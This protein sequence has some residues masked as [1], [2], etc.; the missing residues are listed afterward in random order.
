MSTIRVIALATI[1]L[2][3]STSHVAAHNK[4]V[5][6]PMEGEEA[7]QPEP[8]RWA[9]VSFDGTTASIVGSSGVTSVAKFTN[10]SVTVTFDVPITECGLVVSRNVLGNFSPAEIGISVT[11]PGSNSGHDARVFLL[12]ES[13]A[14]DTSHGVREAFT[15]QALC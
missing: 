14:F 11:N 9:K 8:L 15:I 3:L 1:A 2:G 4:V 7:A 6:I 10:E 5:V 13:G 12:T